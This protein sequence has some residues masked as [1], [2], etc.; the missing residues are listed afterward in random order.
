MR[1]HNPTH[2]EVDLQELDWVLKQR[3]IPLFL[4]RPSDQAQEHIA[5]RIDDSGSYVAMF[6]AMAKRSIQLPY[7]VPLRRLS[8]YA[9]KLFQTQED[10]TDTILSLYRW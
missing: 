1:S 10:Y 7:S 8:G 9:E 3:R 2:L 6:K 4:I 5:L